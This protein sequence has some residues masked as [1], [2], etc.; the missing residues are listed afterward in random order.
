MASNDSNS[1]VSYLKRIGKSVTFAGKEAFKNY[2]PH[3]TSLINKNEDYVKSLYKDIS[4]TAQDMRQADRIK[5]PALFST[6]NNGW[7]NLKTSIKTG[8]FFDQERADEAEQEA[9]FAILE[10]MDSMGG[11]SDS[12]QSQMDGNEDYSDDTQIRGIPEVTKG[13]QLVATYTGKQIRASTNAIS[14]TIAN[15]ADLNYRAT[16]LTSN[17]QLRALQQQASVMINGF[18]NIDNG[19]Q[20]L[21]SFNDQVMQVHVQNSRLY[22]ETMTGI[23]QEN[24]AILKEMLDIQRETYQASINPPNQNEVN[25]S[26]ISGLFDNGEFNLQSYF[27]AVKGRADNSL[28]GM[29]FNALSAL[30]AA[31]G[32]VLANPLH[33]VTQKGIE[34]LIDDNLKKAITKFDNSINSYIET[35]LVKMANYAKD[36]RLAGGILQSLAKRFGF[37]ENKFNIK[38]IDT[39]KYHKGAL[40]WNGIAQRALVE[41]IPGHLRRIEAAISGDSERVYDF[42]NG[43]WTTMRNIQYI[44]KDLDRRYIGSAMKPVKDELLARFGGSKE[45]TR[46]RRIL[47]AAFD[48]F[49]KGVAQRGMIDFDHIQNNKSKYGSDEDLVNFIL[50]ALKSGAIDQ[51][52]I[53]QTTSRLS[54][55]N[56]AMKQEADFMNI[57]QQ[58]LLNEYLNNSYSDKY[59]RGINSFNNNTI[60]NPETGERIEYKGYSPQ[61]SLDNIQDERGNTLYDY[62]FNILNTI[63]S[64]KDYLFNNENSIKNKN[65]NHNTNS[66]QYKNTSLEENN[67]TDIR[68]PIIDQENNNDENININEESNQQDDIDNYND[69]RIKPISYY[70]WSLLNRNEERYNVKDSLEVDFDKLKKDPEY[71]DLVL[72]NIIRTGK[73]AVYDRENNNESLLKSLINNLSDN[74]ELRK[75]VGE[76]RLNSLKDKTKNITGKNE[77]SFLTSMLNATSVADK[78]KVLSDSLNFIYKSPQTLLTTVISTADK[79]IY[80]F[81]FEENQERDEDGKPIKGFFQKIQS[82]FMKT[83]DTFNTNFNKWMKEH[84]KDGA[85]GISG[86][87]KELFEKIGIDVDGSI[88]NLKQL[89]KKATESLF[90]AGRSIFG[91]VKDSVSKSVQDALWT[92]REV[93]E[94]N[95]E[96]VSNQMANSLHQFM[97]NGETGEENVFENT[98]EESSDDILDFE[99]DIKENN[100]EK[101]VKSEQNEVTENKKEKSKEKEVKN[102]K[103][104][105]KEKQEEKQSFT[106]GLKSLMG[107]LSSQIQNGFGDDDIPTRA[108]GITKNTKYGLAVV[109]PGEAIIPANLNPWNPNREHADLRSQAINESTY[110]ERFVQKLKNNVLQ[111]LVSGAD[112]YAEGS[113]NITEENTEEQKPNRKRNFKSKPGFFTKGIQAILGIEEPEFTDS[114]YHKQDF[115]KNAVNQILKE[116]YN[117]SR[118]DIDL[119]ANEEK[120]KEFLKKSAKK[121]ANKYK[122]KK[123]DFN[124]KEFQNAINY[125]LT[126]RNFLDEDEDYRNILFDLLSNADYKGQF[127]SVKESIRKRQFR[128]NGTFDLI[129]QFLTN[130]FGTNPEKVIKDTNKFIQKNIGDITSGGVGGAIAGTIFPLGGP[131]IGAVAG[132]AI[133]LIKNNKKFQNYMFGDEVV[134]EKGNKTREDN[135][136]FS[137]KFI[138][139]IQK[140]IPDAKKYGIAGTLAGL[141]LPFGPLGGLMIGSGISFLKNNNTFQNMMFGE[142][143]GLINKDRKEKIK[144][145]LPQITTATLGTLFLGPFGLMGNAVLGAGLG[146]I[147]TTES[148]KRIMLGSK[149]RNGVRR[150]GI[151]GVIRRQITDPFKKSMADMSS[152]IAKW[153]KDDIFNPVSR[154]LKPIGRVILGTTQDAING[155]LK[156]LFNTS[157]TPWGR[158]LVKGLDYVMTGVRKSGGF[159]KW[160]VG[161][162]IGGGGKLAAKQ[163]EKLSKNTFGRYALKKGYVGDTTA[164]ERIKLAQELGKDPNDSALGSLDSIIYKISSQE[165]KDKA[166]KQLSTIQAAVDAY[167]DMTSMNRNKLNSN[168]KAE[169][170]NANSTGEKII[171]EYLDAHKT[172]ENPHDKYK[173]YMSFVEKMNEVGSNPDIDF[174][175]EMG[176]FRNKVAK[177][178]LPK[179]L[180]DKLMEQFNESA[181]NIAKYRNS[182]RIAEGSADN[183]E[184]KFKLQEQI[185]KAIGLDING[186]DAKKNREILDAILSNS[187]TS[188]ALQNDINML[189]DKKRQL[190]SLNV[191]QE[192]SLRKELPIEDQIA[193]E[194][195]DKQIDLLQEMVNNL[196]EIHKALTTNLNEDEA[197]KIIDSETP[198]DSV[199]EEFKA[200]KAISDQRINAA[201]KVQNKYLADDRTSLIEKLTDS[202]IG[203]IIIKLNDP[204]GI[205]KLKEKLN[206]E[207]YQ[208]SSRSDEEYSN[209]IQKISEKEKSIKENNQSK[210][211]A[212][213]EEVEE[214]VN[215]QV[216]LIPY[217]GN[218]AFGI[219][220]IAGSALTYLGNKLT[221][222]DKDESE[223]VTNSVTEAKEEQKKLT[224]DDF[225]SDELRN[226]SNAISQS[227]QSER[228][229]NNE[230]LNNQ[231]NKK[232]NIQ[233]ISDANGEMIAYT[234]GSDGTPVKL[235]N[236]DN[237]DIE[238]RHKHDLSL[239]ERS[240]NALESI[241]SSIGA[242]SKETVGK[243][244]GKL[245]KGLFGGLL[246]SLGGL[247]N[248]LCLGLPVGTWIIKK[249]KTLPLKLFGVLKN[250][251]PKLL[252]KIIP[253]SL[254]TK[255][256][257]IK[258]KLSKVKPKLGSLSSTKSI[259]SIL[260]K[261][262][263]NKK[264]IAVAGA[265]AELYNLL[266]D[267]DED[268]EDSNKPGNPNPEDGNGDGN[269]TPKPNNPNTSTND[270]VNEELKTL[271]TSFIGSKIGQKLFKKSKTASTIGDALE[272]SIEENDMS[273]SNIAT[274]I[275]IDGIIDLISRKLD[276]NKEPIQKSKS[277]LDSIKDKK[278]DI[279]D[280][281]K[282][283]LDSV[284]DKKKDIKNKSKSVLD[285]IKDK[286]DSI[287][288]KSK[289]ILNYIKDK[290]DSVLDSVKDKK[291]YVLDSIKDKKEI[292]KDKSKSVLNSIK[293]ESKSIL[294]SIKDKKE[295]ISNTTKA[296]IGKVKN[297]LKAVIEAVGKYIPGEKAKG[298]VNKLC[299][300]IL[301]KMT[302]PQG[303]KAISKKLAQEAISVGAG[304]ATIGIGYAVFKAG[305]AIGNFIGGVN[306]TE[307]ML[308][309]RP[310]TATTGLKIIAGLTTAICASIPL[311]GVFIPEDW[312]LQQA[313][314]LVGP[315]FGI[316]ESYLNSLRKEGEKKADQD[317]KDASQ[318]VASNDGMLPNQTSSSSFFDKIGV[319]SGKVFDFV[320]DTAVGAAKWVYDKATGA[321]K[322]VYNFGSKVYDSINS[323]SLGHAILHPIDTASNLYDKAKTY[324]GKGKKHISKYGR[325]S[326][327]EFYSQ[328]DPAYAMSMNA[329]GDD[330]KQTM[331][332]S[333]CGPMSA[334]N[335]ISAL[336]G[337]VDPTEAASYA[338]KNGYKEKDG[339]IKPGFFKDYLNKKGIDTEN[340][341]GS[342]E[343]LTQ[344]KQGNPVVLMGKD[345]KG[346][347]PETPYGENPHYVTATGVDN[348]GN[349]TIQDPESFEPNKVYKLS[350]VLNKSSIAIGTNKHGSGK[351]S[352]LDKLKSKFGKSKKPLFGRGEDVG[353]HIW[354]YLSS[355]GLGSLAIAGIMGNMQQESG[356]NP[357]V[358]EGGGES[359]EVNLDSDRG[360]G[361]C[362]WSFSRKQDLANFAQSQG[363]SSGDLETQLDFMLSELSRGDTI[364]K[365]DNAGSAGE[366]AAIFHSDFERSND[367]PEVIKNRMDNAEQ[368]FQ[369]KGKG[370]ATG[371]TFK[372]SGSSSSNNG[373]QGIFGAL[374]ELTNKISSLTNIFGQGKS[375]YGKGK[376]EYGRG[377]DFSTA[378]FE[379]PFTKD[380]TITNPENTNY[381]LTMPTNDKFKQSIK[382]SGQPEK[383][384]TK[385]AAPQ[386]GGLMQRFFGSAGSYL[387]KISSPLKAATSQFKSSLTSGLMKTF[388]K[389]E[390]LIGPV[391]SVF[392][393]IFGSSN[394]NSNSSGG[395]FNGGSVAVPNSGSAASAMQT[396]LNGA[397]IT[398]PYGPRG[399]G[400]HSGNDFGIDSGTELPTVVDGVVDDVGVDANGYGNFIVVKDNNGY[401]HIFGHLTQAKAAKGQSVTAG[402]VIA[403]SGH[404]GHCI[405]DGPDGSH[406]HYGIY[407]SSNPNCAGRN[408]SVDPGTYNIAG[409]SG[410]AKGKYGSGKKGFTGGTRQIKPK[411][412]KGSDEGMKI[413]YKSYTNTRN[414]T[415]SG[416]GKK[417]LF[418]MGNTF[419]STIQEDIYNLRNNNELIEAPSDIKGKNTN[420]GISDDM[421]QSSLFGKG[422]YGQGFSLKSIYEQGKKYYD[423]FK[424]IKKAYENIK[425]NKNQI[426]ATDQDNSSISKV[427]KEPSK[428]GHHYDENGNIIYDKIDTT[429]NIKPTNSISSIQKRN[430]EEG[431]ELPTDIQTDIPTNVKPSNAISSIQKRNPEEGIE[432]SEDTQNNNKEIDKYQERLDKIESLTTNNEVLNQISDIHEEEIPEYNKINDND[433][434]LVVKAKAKK[435]ISN[436]IK[437]LKDS[438]KETNNKTNEYQERLDKIESLNNEEILKQIS[439]IP[440]EEI[441]EY[442]RIKDTDDNL[443]MK[444]KAKKTI[445][446]Y[447]K[448]LQ[449]ITGNIIQNK[450]TTN[451]KPT[452]SISSIQKRSPEDGIELT[453]KK[454]DS[455]TNIKPSN[456][457]ASIQKRSPEEGIELPDDNK[458][459]TTI[460]PTNTIPSIQKKNPEE[461]IEL[462]TDKNNNSISKVQK[463]PSKYGHHY[464]ESGNIIYDKID[465]TNIKPTNSISSI[466]KRNPEEGIELPD[467]NK[468]NEYQERL[469]KI[470]SLT[471]NEDILKQI[472][473]IPKE[474][475]PEYNRI[476]DN[477]DILVVK[478]KA[479]KTISNHIKK[480]KDEKINKPKVQIPE[481]NK[482]D[483]ITKAQSEDKFQLGE[484]GSH[485]TGP[486]GK[487]Y[488]NNDILYILNNGDKFNGASTIEDA[489]NILSK[490]KK[491]TE[492][493]KTNDSNS[494]TTAG[495]TPTLDLNNQNTTNPNSSD[496]PSISNNQNDKLDMMI[497]AQNKTNEL[498]SAIVNIASTFVNNANGNTN[499]TTTNTVNTIN[500]DTKPIQKE[501]KSVNTNSNMSPESMALK[502]QLTYF[503]NNSGNIGIDTNFINPDL[504]HSIDVIKRMQSIASM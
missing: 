406:L 340:L 250:Q 312:V 359:D 488:T 444:A 292:I 158:S 62:Q 90:D 237:A 11:E 227:V 184:A 472:S 77:K 432:L 172:E 485:G 460:K 429:T 247:I 317:S 212:T 310:G 107:N 491:Y 328:L 117:A 93:K 83:V 274:N 451:I 367:G 211:L 65:K 483:S 269:E 203:N 12:I 263:S 248:T 476:N 235:K 20:A 70:T 320:K 254:K 402:Q 142:K 94:T 278:E 486:N 453:D 480:L 161:G 183:N 32:T 440:E 415:K 130:A 27:N 382:K 128:R 471:S 388:G 430:P 330:I 266:G 370:I 140:Y 112:Q 474:E 115:I 88:K 282:S 167:Q 428:Y 16:K 165:D 224:N 129:S 230:N 105:Q 279:K 319:Y 307:E 85:S 35:G 373:P 29:L 409:L 445:S 504:S 404:S 380:T 351:K 123:I 408:G 196:Q 396:A 245:G 219:R 407:D 191:A 257:K 426:P 13:D 468:I 141:V 397:E 182:K 494:S 143:G 28:P 387:D 395:A 103:K 501:T 45:D 249:L 195:S 122:K 126:S 384:A 137:K 258:P 261:L 131:L 63:T 339:G 80:D 111:N 200:K 332:D 477:D 54:Q 492:I 434:I 308:N 301:K 463:E 153:F 9:A 99:D 280:K 482:T 22:F 95:Q 108:Y 246:D 55:A 79:F 119:Y 84:F 441:P 273:L 255:L 467:D 378:N 454:I 353:E 459:N 33:F 244:T 364:S 291:D 321:A 31:L 15:S 456:S 214:E 427:Q 256:S 251:I 252:Q 452:N 259:K 253:K 418:G 96:K 405:P 208:Q 127:D 234:Q 145:A 71:K 1:I 148:F 113:P 315:A 25:P 53:V 338:L 298:A 325:G 91:T 333:G 348:Q 116:L 180:Q 18:S 23:Q 121:L 166:Q 42:D 97:E 179:E 392:T 371:S 284:K 398:S 215:R 294:S 133:N 43:K 206:N 475:I 289:S 168:I 411:F 369:T 223:E 236:K 437:K 334:S 484:E 412:T 186:P 410:S 41:V 423:I 502:N 39:S 466:Q 400:F 385:P 450:I 7:K 152:N 347:S 157:E 305:F 393:S 82:T 394:S 296:A 19:I 34:F 360:Y 175:A 21:A 361:L 345:D 265:A 229:S 358:M 139:N 57:T 447:I 341:H 66:Y 391:S 346:E 297:N 439:D 293:D 271:A 134:D 316:T 362:Q 240:C 38:S 464:D 299:N 14:K 197:D 76:E 192:K 499:N 438:N 98:K 421:I 419:K 187:H 354:N 497:A 442:N 144:K 101:E 335:A 135:G 336:G 337:S 154:G 286:K 114:E 326:S 209:T 72:A 420:F 416:L 104:K 164:E 313:I 495:T 493:T 226:A 232:K 149:D 431:I 243:A 190:T 478:A 368:A 272:T 58:S 283:V 120:K 176:R 50:M 290:K 462:S 204:M 350:N 228:K 106:E 69:K 324:F 188:D 87:T 217:Y 287:K 92:D 352:I 342:K 205:F 267:S 479:K 473:D 379:N 24:N 433:D 436:H 74:D 8:N 185:A 414:N 44:Q 281:S 275:G 383:P 3:T 178:N 323:T 449:E 425:N 264:S 500:T 470:E 56:R 110:K 201:Q 136:I 417:P 374:S 73:E 177:S 481:Q 443:V 48:E 285:Y 375:K 238:A 156:K 181:V 270:T 372:G 4:R 233:Y 381:Q 365:M 469:D 399:S 327:G 461:G 75:F 357:K 132:S 151:A 277:V 220:S 59:A 169:I 490:D 36:N 457:I 446:N 377:F 81:L 306:Q 109:G 366:A 311:I 303:L 344:L 355:K 465:T 46:Q 64:I 174:N 125:V 160:A 241:A 424:Q 218:N 403:I 318:T 26:E 386:S 194:K 487:A 239:R 260:T 86:W 147:S 193:L 309:L 60:Y 503:F 413:N 458:I 498:L 225:T 288:D 376:S 329:P 314:R 159:G 6:L 199:V 124:S 173:T 363:K 37:K 100:E 262:A 52:A 231:N 331:A 30:P 49:S 207:I 300:A 222:K 5:D 435:T 2:M 170:D 155:T 389:Y 448:K 40:Q 356:F 189:Q 67:D 349:I 304:A 68:Q 150:G 146:L 295:D 102:K 10:F 202:I 455:T 89:K 47:S 213:K 210:P 163:F 343:I 496:I 171:Q 302:S 216:A 61:L 78:F 276:K 322:S 268:L 17:L 401:Y 242:K 118:E 51:S 422:K 162:L 390:S 221:G 138:A 198:T 489:V